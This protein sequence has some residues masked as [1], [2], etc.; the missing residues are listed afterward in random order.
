M[1]LENLLYTHTSAPMHTDDFVEYFGLEKSFESLSF[2]S[3]MGLALF[4]ACLG[5]ITLFTLDNKL[6]AHSIL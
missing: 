2:L 6:L 3:V 1:Q 5:L 4:W